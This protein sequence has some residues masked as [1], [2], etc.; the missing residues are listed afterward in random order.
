MRAVGLITEYNPFHNG[1]LHHLRESRKA[2]GA[3]VAVAVM[4][5]HFL[6]RGEPALVDKWTRAEMALRA[7]VDLV[8]ELPFPWAC[9]SAPHFAA[10]AVR[11]L[12]ALG[13]VEA[14]CFG[15]EAGGIGPLQDCAELL[16][17]RAEQIGEETA[18]LLRSGMGYPAA[19]QRVVESLSGAGEAGEVLKT[20]NNILGIA[21]L[22]AL[23]EAGSSIRPLTVPR[24]GAGYHDAEAVGGIASA[25]GIRRMFAEGREV[26]PFIPA[27][28]RSPLEQALA[29]GR[30]LEPDHLYR[31]LLG[32]IFRGPSSL[33]SVYQVAD[34]IENRICEAAETASGYEELVDAVKSRHFTRTRIQRL[35]AYILNEVGDDD[36]SAF[37]DA[38]P[39]YLHVLGFSGRGRSF[40]A[41]CRKSLQLPLVQNYS[42]VHAILKRHY[43][44]DTERGRLAERMLALELRATRNYTLLLRQW[45]GGGRGLDFYR[46]AVFV[47]G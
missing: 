23:R 39:L 20:P 40:L 44:P 37:L 5:G 35:L 13:G 28:A 29:S 22:K 43:G 45:P 36:M 18:A 1:H 2:A 24:V 25:T 46:E 9:N 17:E 10:G 26:A 27:A 15:S 31:L 6:Q 19:R 38:G 3:E 7:G 42:R 14:L 4:S 16:Q 33:R 47:E 8:L 21:Y 34:G 30:S 12:E 11:A 41:A 32:R